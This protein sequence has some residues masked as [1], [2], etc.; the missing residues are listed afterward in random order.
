MKKV[1]AVGANDLDAMLAEMTLQDSTC[2]YPKCKKTI[3]L[4]GLRCQFCGQGNEAMFS[5]MLELLTPWYNMCRD[6]F[7]LKSGNDQSK[8]SS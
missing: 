6:I 4:L 3:K 7:C 2:G 1:S 8:S 5:E